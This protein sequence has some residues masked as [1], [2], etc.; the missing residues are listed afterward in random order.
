M[1][2][3]SKHETKCFRF[4]CGP[5]PGACNLT[6]SRQPLRKPIQAPRRGPRRPFHAWPGR[7]RVEAG[8]DEAGRGPVMGPLVVAGVAVE[9]PQRLSDLGCRDSKALHPGKREAIHRLLRRDTGVRIA[10]RVVD[11]AGLD[12]ERRGGSTLNEIEAARFIEIAREL[13]CRRVVVDAADVDAPRFGR[14]V[15]AG[16]DPGIEVVSEHKADATHATVAAASIVA[17]VTRDEAVA[18]LG[19]RL[20][21]K[22]GRQL[23]SGYPSDPKTRAFLA[24]WIAQFGELPEGCRATWATA[25]DALAAARTRRLDDF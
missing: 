15:A 8:I 3:C 9:D 25:R 4:S 5:D 1:V 16:L 17:K 14:T 23:G 6:V 24:A 11:A 2:R 7:R 19:R 10:V 12:A 22:L 13:G 18:E 21:R 20:E